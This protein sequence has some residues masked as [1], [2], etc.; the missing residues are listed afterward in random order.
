[1][2]Q[3]TPAVSVPTRYARAPAPRLPESHPHLDLDRYV[4]AFLTWIANKLSRGASQHYLRSFGVGIETWRCLVLLANEPTISASKVCRV[5]GMDKASV[6]RCFAGMEAR[7][8]IRVSPDPADGR[9]R[10]ATLTDKGRQL[11]NCIMGVAL[12][13]ERA[14]LSV[15]DDAEREVLIGLLR[16]LHENL[17]AVEAA[18]ERYAATLPAP[19]RGRARPTSEEA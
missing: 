7:K 9:A 17:P 2:V 1:M 13:R 19:R 11:H 12:E 4:P 6:S 16:R 8:L 10:V 3:T 18:T 14:L 15:L 5:I